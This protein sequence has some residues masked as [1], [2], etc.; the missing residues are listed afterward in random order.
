M[1]NLPLE[2]YTCFVEQ[3]AI[4]ERMVMGK[5]VRSNFREQSWGCRNLQNH[6]RRCLERHGL[7]CIP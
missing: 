3:S 5:L 1:E 4:E 6:H 7:T 2:K